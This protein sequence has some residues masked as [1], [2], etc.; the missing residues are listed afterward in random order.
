MQDDQNGWKLLAAEIYRRYA[1]D[2]PYL[3]MEGAGL[4]LLR[5]L[6][7]GCAC[8]EDYSRRSCCLMGFG[9]RIIA[10][11]G[12]IERGGWDGGV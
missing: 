1:R 12:M 4:R 3:G 6:F 7:R 9:G 10:A 11:R 2:Q 8:D 5:R